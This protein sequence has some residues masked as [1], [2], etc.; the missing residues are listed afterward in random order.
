MR[1][2]PDLKAW[3][4]LTAGVS[5]ESGRYVSFM[6]GEWAPMRF[7]GI[8]EVY[9]MLLT[10]QHE[11]GSEELLLWRPAWIP[12]C[13]YGASDF[14]S[15]LLLDAETGKIRY[16]SGYGERSVRF[17]SLSVYLEEMADLLETPAISDGAKP[18]LWNGALMWGPPVSAD[19][20]AQWVE[21]TG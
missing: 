12:I 2:P 21:F 6:L 10:Q 15:G 19:E 3:W 18:G 7:D 16:W 17:E 11:T 5:A 4:R 9:R 14:T 20:A 13:T 8:I 1:I